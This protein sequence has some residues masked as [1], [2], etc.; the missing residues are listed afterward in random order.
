MLFESENKPSIYDQIAD[1]QRKLQLL[2]SDRNAYYENSHST[3]EKNRQAILQ[4]REENRELQKS[5]TDADTDEQQFVQAALHGRGV[6][7]D[8][9]PPMSGK[10]ALAKLE[11]RVASKIKRLNA[12]K[13][14]TLTHQRR[15]EDLKRECLRME[16]VG[17]NLAMTEK[18]DITL[19]LRS[20][21]NC[22][23]KNQLKCKEGANIMTN[24]L[25]LKRH[26][27]EE[28]LTFQ[29]QIDSL[30]AEIMKF[31]RELQDVQEMNSKAQMSKETAIAELQQQE[32]LF[33]KEHQEKDYLLAI[34]RKRVQEIRARAEK[35]DAQ[36]KIVQQD[37]LNNEADCSTAKMAAELDKNICIFE[38]TLRRMKDAT[39]YTNTEEVMDRYIAQQKTHQHLQDLKAEN[40][41]VILQLKERKEDL[42]QQF[43][44]IKYSGET[45]LSSE[46]KMLEE[47]EQGL[48]AKQQSCE[49]AKERLA[50]LVKTLST[51]QAGVEHLAER[52]DH[53]SL[54]EAPS[55]VSP[56]AD[57]FVVE[58]LTQCERKLQLL[59]D[60]L[61]GKD[62]NEIAKDMEE[63][64]FYFMIEKQLPTY[65]KRV[66][67]TEDQE[68]SLEN[69]EDESEED[70]GVLTREALKRRSQAMI[71]AMS[72]KKSW[73]LKKK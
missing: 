44:D 31:K 43:E 55:N 27:Q 41:Y 62:L 2:E 6:E 46:Q 3:L 39:G 16:A 36:R 5:V 4:L 60:R 48:L 28:S 13:H 45:Q 17:S 25:K 37:E 68:M 65:N 58:L 35:L 34:Y 24:Y 70:D 72:N 12:L 33:Y 73:K 47:C 49:I 53:I 42:K 67:V 15:L 22:L 52:L 20:L 66:T 29:G 1:L 54:N 19:K 10:A 21:Q 26:L 71:D 9:G 50:S 23:E 64:E 11:H 14:T 32:E 8:T 30:E 61:R 18:E 38:E 63:E 56:N 57:E 51:I 7:K 59:Q 69:N 40:E